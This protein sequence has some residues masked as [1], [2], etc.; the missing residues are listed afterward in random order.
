MRV[1]PL[2]GHSRR[3]SRRL[4]GVEA[5]ERREMLAVDWRNPVDSLDVNSDGFVSSIDALLIINSLNTRGE[6]DLPAERDASSP[7]LD[8]DGDQSVSSADA[9]RVINAINQ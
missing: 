8:V 2:P 1:P 3:L 4:W 7:F 9:L 5:L 6:P